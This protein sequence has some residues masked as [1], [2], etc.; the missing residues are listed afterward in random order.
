MTDQIMA[1]DIMNYPFTPEGMEKFW[2]NAPDATLNVE[3]LMA[4]GD[5]VIS[6]MTFSFT[7]SQEYNGI[8]ATGNKIEVST[9]NIVRIEDGKIIEERES[10]DSLGWMKQLGYTIQPPK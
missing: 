4:T 1:I 10:V 2:E 8:P 3:E 7:H 9:I 6:I 5:K